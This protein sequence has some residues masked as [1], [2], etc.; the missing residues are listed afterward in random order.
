MSTQALDPINLLAIATAP[1][2]PTLRIG[3]TYFNTATN[4]LFIY[5]G[6]AWVAT[7]PDLFQNRL[8]AIANTTIAAGFGSYVSDAFTISNGIALTISDTAILE[9]G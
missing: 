6:S 9:I 2:L 7:V 3:D 5:T 8:S 1:T 4:S